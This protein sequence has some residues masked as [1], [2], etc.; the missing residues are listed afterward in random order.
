MLPIRSTSKFK[1]DLKRAIKPNRNIKKLQ[2]IL[3]RLA[4]PAPLPKKHQDHKLKGE[5]VDFR[6]CHIETDWLMIY[7]I[8]DFELRPVRIGTHSELFD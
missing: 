3:T 8:S 1:K 7:T 6:E 4:I 5:W 2:Q